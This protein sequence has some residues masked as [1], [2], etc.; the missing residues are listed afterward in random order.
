MKQISKEELIQYFIEQLG[1]NSIL[2]DY[3]SIEEIRE[4]LNKNILVVVF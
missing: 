1:D 3:L 2:N 4:R